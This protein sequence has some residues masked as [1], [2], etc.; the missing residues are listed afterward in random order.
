MA[1][2]ALTS[3]CHATAAFQRSKIPCLHFPSGFGGLTRTTNQSQTYRDSQDLVRPNFMVLSKVLTEVA[4]LQ[5]VGTTRVTAIALPVSLL[6]VRY[7]S[8]R[9]VH[10][11]HVCDDKLCVWR[12]NKDDMK[13]L[14]DRGIFAT[15]LEGSYHWLGK[16]CHNYGHLNAAQLRYGAHIF[17]P[18]T[19]FRPSWPGQ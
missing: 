11:A 12:P 16:A 6:K 9:R 3:F 19:A 2:G 4:F 18:A 1:H 10:L 7:G 17:F 5:L 15:Y 13:K 14:E 8:S